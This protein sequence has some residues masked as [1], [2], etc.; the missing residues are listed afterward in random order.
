MEDERRI[1]AFALLAERERAMR[2]AAEAGRRQLEYNRR[3]EFDEMFRQLI[4]MNQESVETYLEDVIK[5]GIEWMSDKAAKEYV[6]DL[7]D[8]V[9]RVAKYTQNK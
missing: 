7:C 3:R 8:K 6:L 4:K 5:E 1:H 2:E 9:D